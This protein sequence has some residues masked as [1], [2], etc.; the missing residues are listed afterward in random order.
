MTSDGRIHYDVA[1]ILV[2]AD[3]H[4]RK[5]LHDLLVFRDV[6]SGKF[7]QKVVT[8]GHAMA[9]DDAFQL[10]QGDH[11][12]GKIGVT[13]AFQRNFSKYGRYLTQSGKVDLG[14]IADDVSSLLQFLRARQTGAGRQVHPLGQFDIGHSSVLLQFGKDIDV[15]PVEL[16]YRMP[17]AL[18][19]C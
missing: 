3:I 14:R 1:E 12:A 2:D 16:H 4:V 6:T 7:D 18:A 19:G 8:A 11:K 5:P 10:V 17:F 9:F 15:D 13:V